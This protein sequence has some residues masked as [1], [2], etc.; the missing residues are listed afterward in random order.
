LSEEKAINLTS[1]LLRELD[2]GEMV[3]QVSYRI[4]F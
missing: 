1:A 2:I 3:E 4:I